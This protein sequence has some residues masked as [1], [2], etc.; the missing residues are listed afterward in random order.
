MK[1]E[2]SGKA[3]KGAIAV[4]EAEQERALERE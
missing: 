1:A 4:I 3:R 2:K